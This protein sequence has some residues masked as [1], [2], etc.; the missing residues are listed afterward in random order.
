MVQ[1]TSGNPFPIR[2]CDYD[3]EGAYPKYV[4]ERGRRC[5]I[6]F[7]PPDPTGKLGRYRTF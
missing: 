5:V 2:V 4:D 7:E 1:W 6:S 3:V